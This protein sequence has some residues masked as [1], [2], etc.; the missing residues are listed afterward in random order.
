MSTA[1]DYKKCKQCG[2]EF[3]VYE[4]NCRTC[5]WEFD[6]MRC[7]YKESQAWI[8]GE[9]GTRIG[10]K[11]EVLDG[12]GAVWVTPRKHG[13]STS[14]GLRSTQEVEDAVQKMRTAIAN[15]DVNARSSYVTRWNHELKRAE[16]AAGTWY[17]DGEVFGDKLFD[18][19]K[20]PVDVLKPEEE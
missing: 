4:F 9:D 15:D 17:Q 14:F 8:I 5:E 20:F 6:C 13:I 2:Y 11:H 19:A 12:Q 3:G 1:T 18:M 7:G 10:W 16:L